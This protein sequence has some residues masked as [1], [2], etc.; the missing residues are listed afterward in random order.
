MKKVD[1][2]GRDFGKLKV[3]ELAYSKN[4]VL[5]WRCLCA[6]G[7]KKDIRGG[8]LKSGDT[9]SCGCNVKKDLTDQRF[10]RWL[11]KEKAGRDIWYNLLWKCECD[12]GNVVIVNGSSL[13]DGSSLSC[14]CLQKEIIS[15]LMKGIPKSEE[16]RK[17]MSENSSNYNPNLT[18]E[19]RIKNRKIQGYEEWR[20]IVYKV[21][22]YT[23]QKCG[24][25]KGGNLNAHHIESYRTN[26][27]LRTEV[28]NGITLCEDC[29]KDFHHQYGYGDNTRAQLV[30]FLKVKGIV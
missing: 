22:N 23:C 29:H 30:E 9:T 13:R 5:Y 7:N 3:I 25:D 6:C 12:C 19:D 10:G 15:K 28:S 1:L 24:D 26:P 2:T 20:K 14:G 16:Q 27:Y 18:T 11:V 4:G 8:S 21:D 17:R